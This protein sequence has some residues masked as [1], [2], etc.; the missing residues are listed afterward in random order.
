MSVLVLLLQLG[1]DSAYHAQRGCPRCEC[2][3]Q[4]ES[5]RGRATKT[6]F[7]AIVDLEY[8]HLRS[9]GVNQA[10]ILRIENQI[11][12]NRAKEGENLSCKIL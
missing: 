10:K 7:E 12:R 3:G 5:C 8:L 11:D 4:E 1:R 6:T 2:T 9:V